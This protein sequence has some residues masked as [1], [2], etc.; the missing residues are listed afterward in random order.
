MR[1]VIAPTERGAALDILEGNDGEANRLLM[2]SGLGDYVFTEDTS[3]AFAVGAAK[4]NTVFVADVNGDGGECARRR[5]TCEHTR[6]R[7][8]G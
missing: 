1:A 5:A 6:E 3:S 8:R 7:T 2:N 4:T